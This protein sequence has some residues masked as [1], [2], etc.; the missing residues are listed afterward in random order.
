MTQITCRNLV[1]HPIL[2]ENIL[3][4]RVLFT[5]PVSYTHLDVYKRQILHSCA[6]RSPKLPPRSISTLSRRRKLQA[7]TAS[8]AALPLPLRN[9]ALPFPQPHKDRSC[10]SFSFIMDENSSLRKYGSC[11]PLTCNVSG[12]ISTGPTVN[13]FIVSSPV[14][15]S[16]FRL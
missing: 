4:R 8:I 1:Q 3:C 2:I 5:I 11:V 10:C 6:K 9:S 7:T 16:Y 15:C 13:S 12:Y 14:I